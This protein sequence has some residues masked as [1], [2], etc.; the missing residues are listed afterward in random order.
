MRSATT[1]T[2]PLVLMMLLSL[3]KLKSKPLRII[4]GM[5]NNG[6][7]TYTVTAEL[8]ADEML[9]PNTLAKH[10]TVKRMNHVGNNM[11]HSI[12]RMRLPIS[13]NEKVCTADNTNRMVS[14]D[15]R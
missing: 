4:C 13:T 1:G 9:S 14:F 10:D 11:L 2:L 3:S 15:I 12:S 7:M 6:I 8:K 5:S